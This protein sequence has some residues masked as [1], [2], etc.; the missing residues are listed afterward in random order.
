MYFGL[1]AQ[2]DL[3][4]VAVDQNHEVGVFI[5]NENT[6]VTLADVV[7]SDTQPAAGTGTARGIEV[8]DRAHLL[9][10][11]GALERN[12]DAALATYH[13]GTV[14]TLADLLVRDSLHRAFDVSMGARLDLSRAALDGN[15]DDG[16]AIDG[17][18]TIMTF[19]D[20]IIRDTLSSS[21]DGLGGSGRAVNAQFGAHVDLTRVALLRNQDLGVFAGGAGT[22]VTIIDLLVQDTR[23][24][25]VD[26]QNGGAIGAREGAGVSVT[27]GRF[28]RNRSFG[29]SADDPGTLVTL[30]DV[31][32]ADTESRESDRRAGMGIS[33]LSGARVDVA[34]ARLERNRGFGVFAEAAGTIVTL[35]D[36]V[37]ADTRSEESGLHFGRGLEVQY[38]ATADVVR[39]SF[40]RN[41]DVGVIAAG[42]GTFVV[43]T[44][45]VISGTQDQECEAM[46]GCTWRVAA[47]VGSYDGALLDVRRFVFTDNAFLGLQLGGGE[48]DMHDGEVSNNDIGANVQTPDFD[49]ARIQDGVV[50]RD[51]GITLDASGLPV[52]MPG[53]PLMG[54]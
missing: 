17:A 36:V 50:W 37:I 4:R 42:P 43:L 3:T 13:V 22:A 46:A 51:N 14:V 5:A 21:I 53:A 8:Q 47:A 28:E 45:I 52:P 32:I 19:T 41:R 27:R 6:L 30:S 38:G 18:G 31:V 40:E 15:H 26:L 29:L 11:R 10:T 2:V 54:P 44:D 48:A 33:V 34:R 24:R 35:A 20:V 49:V 23:R 7:V 9:I 12:Q 1:G 25:E 39:A 16:A